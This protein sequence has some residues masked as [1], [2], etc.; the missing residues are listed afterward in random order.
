MAPPPPP[1]PASLSGYQDLFTAAPDSP[2]R[3]SRANVAIQRWRYGR[4]WFTHRTFTV[5]GGQLNVCPLQRDEGCGDF[6][7]STTGKSPNAAIWPAFESTPPPEVP[8]ERGPLPSPQAWVHFAGGR[9][10]IYALRE[11][12]GAI[13]RIDDQGKVSLLVSDEALKG[14]NSLWVAEY[15]ARIFVAGM[16][17]VRSGDEIKLSP[18][19][20]GEV[21][22]GKPDEPRKLSPLVE[23]PMRPISPERPNAQGA[24]TASQENKQAMLGSPRLLPLPDEGA[25]K[26]RWAMAWLEIIPPPYEWP[27]EKPQKGA[28]VS[29]KRAKK[30]KHDCGGPASRPFD[31][32]SM[33]KR[34]HV[35][36]FAGT[37]L[38]SDEVAWSAS[39]LGDPT[40][41]DLAPRL[42]QDQVVVAPPSSKRPAATTASPLFSESNESPELTRMEDPI[43][44]R[45]DAASGEGLV[46]ATDSDLTRYRRFNAQGAPLG[47]PASTPHR[48]DNASFVHAQGQWLAMT[49]SYDHRS[50]LHNLSASTGPFRV[51]AGQGQHALLP[52]P[53]GAQY[54]TVYLRKLTLT[55]VSPDGKTGDPVPLED[56]PEEFAAAENPEFVRLGGRTV[57]VLFVPPGRAARNSRIAWRTLEPE[58]SWEQIE[59]P[60]TAPVHSYQRQLREVGSELVAVVSREDKRLLVWLGAKKVI[61]TELPVREVDRFGAPVP[62]VQQG[63]LLGRGLRLTETPGAPAADPLLAGVEKNCRLSLSTG[64]RTMV[65]ACAHGTDPTNPS[66]HA[67]LRLLRLPP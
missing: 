21:I 24:R 45:F 17:P 27:R 49:T 30:G 33:T 53:Q 59:L 61:E 32:A 66:V 3:H 22:E 48:L 52:A 20:L 58:A 55:P 62:V 26:G 18:W 16:G 15:G 11:G 19:R 43:A 31:D 7:L 57:L 36:I 12:G 14:W 25:Q 28:N 6:S 37:S 5:W 23:L 8:P 42:E 10:A 50:E 4:G 44:I 38:Q 67:G 56:L 39:K 40:R 46:V 2:Q 60:T 63:P 47:E 34:A 13:D 64:P 29:P 54:A 51:P 1:P 65:L 9:D 35:T 41:F